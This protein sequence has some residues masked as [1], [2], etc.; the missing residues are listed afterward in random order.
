MN[1]KDF[2]HAVAQ[3]MGIPTKEANHLT[4]AFIQDFADH[5]DDGTTFTVQGFGSFEVKKKKER[6]V[7]N[8]TTKLR[9]LIPPK[10][11]LSF[12]PGTVLKEKLK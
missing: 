10:L 5:A 12:R 7:V 6:V 3:R 2:I 8:P 11:V 4:T 9:M 1:N